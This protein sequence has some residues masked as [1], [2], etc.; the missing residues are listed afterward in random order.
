MEDD[1]AELLQITD[2]ESSDTEDQDH[3]HCSST[4]T[5]EDDNYL[6]NCRYP[7]TTSYSKCEFITTKIALLFSSASLMILLP[8]YL[9]SMN[10]KSDAYTLILLN[11]S[12]S[13]LFLDLIFLI[14]KF[15]FKSYKNLWI[16]NYPI[17]LSK[18]I[19][20]SFL[21]TSSIFLIIYAV[22]RKRVMC[23]LQDPMKGTI[24]V[25]SLLYYFIFCR[26]F[27]GLQRIFSATT[28]IVGLF[29]A[30]DYGLCDEFRC[31]GYERVRV[32]DD[33]GNWPWKTHTTWI[34]VYVVGLA[35]FSGFYT[36]LERYLLITETNDTPPSNNT[37]SLLTTISRTVAFPIVDNGVNIFTNNG[38]S[39]NERNSKISAVHI[40]LL[41]HVLGWIMIVSMFWTDIIPS[42]GKGS[43]FT[44]FFNLS[45]HGVIC[46]FTPQLFQ[47][48]DFN[49]CGNIFPFSWLFLGSYILF[50]IV[51]V[52]F[53]M[54]SQSA[55]Y[56]IAVM[57]SSLPIVGIWWSLFKL[58]PLQ[59]GGSSIIWSPSLSGELICSL[60]GLPIVLIGLFLFYKSHFR[61]N[62]WSGL[63]SNYRS[64]PPHTA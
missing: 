55:V 63:T 33:T 47:N 49:D 27:M 42:I 46:H 3:E 20:L 11:S 53:L 5:P 64:T 61:D 39:N 62:Q 52:K 9:D 22:D 36:L 8:A 15:F 58:V 21:Y 41:I 7:I 51:S 2:D 54:I 38:Q 12:F 57:S 28:I 1:H 45:N 25:F 16:T 24:L 29:I 35:L 43:S 40:S 32:S 17:K 50:S 6:G 48:Q 19:V 30:V 60:L 37:P 10:V 18:L 26:K 14:G 44:D 59:N 34:V 56:T 4:E 31:R 13:I 23:H